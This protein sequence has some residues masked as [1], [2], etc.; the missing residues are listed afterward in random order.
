[1][2]GKKPIRVVLDDDPTGTQ[3]VHDV[4]VLTCWKKKTLLDQFRRKEDA[5]FIL[6]NT[7]ALTRDDAFHR[8]SQIASNLRHAASKANRAFTILLRGDSTLRSH[9]PAE[10]LA[11]ESMLGP[12]DKW[13]LIP[14]FLQGARVTIAGTHY[15]RQKEGLVPVAQ[16]SFAKDPTF[17]YHQ[18]YLPAWVQE[19][20]AGAIPEQE[21]YCLD[22]VAS[23]AALPAARRQLLNGPKICVVNA[24]SML[25]ARLAADLFQDLESTGMHIL[26]LTAASF[27]SSYLGKGAKLLPPA[28]LCYKKG[29]RTPAGG[30][31]VVGSYVPTTTGQL[32]QLLTLAGLVALELKVPLLLEQP[33]RYPAQLRNELDIALGAGRTVVVFTSR[34]MQR[35]NDGTAFLRTGEIISSALARLVRDLSHAPR[36]LIA[37]GGITASDLATVGLRIKRATVM[38]QALPGVP[39]W[40]AGTE[41]R[42][43]GLPYIIFPGNVG[44][45]HDLVR[46]VKQILR[47][48]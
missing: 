42:Y 35:Q 40:K 28:T 33:R 3:T 20:S 11:V 38:G 39:V 26:Y 18:S 32:R 46:L 43:P 23:P 5:F 6:T 30:L 2:T 45:E 34:E 7:R 36:F 31:I 41:S 37:K 44:V 48:A 24:S 8:I 15:V 13:V 16:T 9:F 29:S 47:H 10:A 14:F 25:H 19:K 17:G 27:V 12:A 21:V 22:L 1:M 4:T